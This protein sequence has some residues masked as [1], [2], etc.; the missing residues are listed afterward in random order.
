M[1]K[2]SVSRGKERREKERKAK[3]G[4][5]AHEFGLLAHL[6]VEGVRAV[7]I[8]QERHAAVIS[9]K[10]GV[11]GGGGVQPQGVSALAQ[12]VHERILKTA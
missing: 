3:G 1:T 10:E 4:K 6:Q 2:W 5:K 12:T 11:V 9:G 7:E 8:H